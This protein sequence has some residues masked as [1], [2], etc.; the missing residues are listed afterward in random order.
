M[1]SNF[2]KPFFSWNNM[3]S[4]LYVITCLITRRHYIGQSKQAKNKLL[5]HKRKLTTGKHENVLLQ[6]DFNRYGEHQFFF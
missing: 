4:G 6:K 5:D 2:T 1:N 3:K